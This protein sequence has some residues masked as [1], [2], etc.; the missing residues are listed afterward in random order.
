[1]AKRSVEAPAPRPAGGEA[2]DASRFQLLV[3]GI[4]DYAIY[5]VSPEGVV[6]SWNAGAQ[7]MKGYKPDEIIGQHF[8]RFFTPEDR[9]A[10]LPQ[11]ALAIAR[12]VGR[13]ESEGWRVR[14]D[15]SR[16]WV[17]AVLD[18][19]H[20]EDGTFIGFAKITRDL[21]ERQAAHQALV[22]SERRFRMLVQGVV[23]YAIY[24]LDPSGIVTNWNAGAERIKGYT[25]GDIVGRHFS[26][27]YTPEE[28]AAGMP[29]KA[30]ATAT[31]EG[32]YE[33]EGWRVRK[34]GTR[35]FAS[36]VIDAIRGDQGEILGFAK[37]TRDITER[38]KSEEALRE[39]ERHFRLLVSGV[40]DYALYML[41]PNG[42][43]TSWNPG[44]MRIKGYSAEEIIGQHF[45]RFYFEGDRAA[46]VPARAL[47]TAG[48]TG[49]YE[50]EGW[51]V[52]KD[53]SF[54][55]ASVIIDAIH[56]EQGALVGFAKITRDITERR[57]A[58]A[59][60][61]RVQSQLAEAQKM[62]ALGQL[63][64][65]VAHD[66][67]NLLM[68]V[69]GHI[70]LLKKQVA[71]DAKSTRAAEAIELAAQRGASLTRQLLTFSRRQ[72]VNPSAIVLSEQ[73]ESF[74]EVLA[75][76][77]GGGERLGVHIPA[78]TWPVKV[79]VSEFEIAL[80]NLVVNA[81]DAMPEGGM[82]T[83]TADNLV[84][85]PPPGETGVSRE[86]VA[87]TVADAGV[88]IPEDVLPRIF[89][90][91]FTTKPVGKGTGLGLSQV[92]GFA[93]QAGGSVKVESGVGKGTRVTMY[94]PRAAT[95]PANAGVQE[96]SRGYTGTC[97]ILLV[98]DNPEVADASMGLL[99]QLGC[100]VRCVADAEAA[101][102]ALERDTTIDLVLSDIVMPGRMD[103]LALA[104][105]VREKYP[106]LQ[107]LLATGY[108]E[109]AQGVDAEFPI[110]RKPYQIGELSKAVA[111][112]MSERSERHDAK[113]V[114]FSP[115]RRG[116][117]SSSGT[118][119]A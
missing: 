66:F 107:V 31:R 110:L 49:R 118:P 14:K 57:E 109:A 13:F 16:L 99:E 78:A 68:I 19:I 23:D 33:A 119:E 103:G 102:Q 26:L 10:G 5:M 80:V 96:R 21:T 73:I 77:V 100:E 98:E 8:S 28:R 32:K 108:S 111:T 24:L 40:T 15:G 1:M 95:A 82:V 34:D 113:L 81:R 93:R 92:Y 53:G 115:G 70:Q 67:N 62:D 39:S 27:F 7:R 72:R 117:G 74:R 44:A 43:V 22:D 91:F 88:G 11:R 76:G 52:R 105:A 85:D 37:V 17:S 51:R 64:G 25:A 42:I 9:N 50:A 54:F 59:N 75:S 63:T 79:D 83:I 46:G 101:L 71:G 4:V 48:Q 106:G 3:Q 112:L 18:A 84:L 61:E 94:L 87:L 60:L 41:D 86:V 36:V 12:R 65:G 20:D 58:Q 97:A 30:L 29:A 35:F 116:G 2:S 56:D 69:S 47:A 38:R 104:R 55:W 90:P 114:Q 89:E 45:S 6:T